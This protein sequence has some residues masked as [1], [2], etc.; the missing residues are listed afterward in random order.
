[1]LGSLTDRIDDLD[2][3]VDVRKES[4]SE[5][6]REIQIGGNGRE[7]EGYFRE[8]EGEDDTEDKMYDDGIEKDL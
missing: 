3:R 5:E 2:G 8:A 1:M 7:V 4:E 6:E